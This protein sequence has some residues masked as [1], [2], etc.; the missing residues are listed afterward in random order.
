M[1]DQERQ[2]HWTLLASRL[3]A[4]PS[5]EKKDESA[6][7]PV[8]PAAS[9][10]PAPRVSEGP[11]Y[12]FTRPEAQRSSTDWL[13]LAEQLG[14]AVDAETVSQASE[15]TTSTEVVEPQAPP[16]V[17][18]APPAVAMEESE[19]SEVDVVDVFSE[20]D[21]Q[22]GDQLVEHVDTEAVEEPRP[23]KKRRRKRRR[24]RPRKPE[25][26]QLPETPELPTSDEIDFGE[27]EAE[28]EAEEEPA[29]PVSNSESLIV[30]PMTS[31]STETPGRGRRRRRRRS[32]RK[33]GDRE[34]AATSAEDSVDESLT[35]IGSEDEDND[36]LLVEPVRTSSRDDLDDDHLDEADDDGG[37]RLVHRGIP[38]WEEA[39]GVVV[40]RNMEAR[41]KNPA[42]QQRSRGNRNRN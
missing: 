42:G 6:P 29:A 36:A 22:L 24:R 37:E 27:D 14:V 35:S 30:S 39:V 20:G 31:T 17:L 11:R 1:T 5:E 2:D 25:E 3:G 21:Q 18:P 28:I 15:E 7:A 40:S 16:A 34:V 19:E 12:S 26:T 38:T 23:D 41:A 4:P 10:E 33:K 13:Q 9:E 32:S 8:E